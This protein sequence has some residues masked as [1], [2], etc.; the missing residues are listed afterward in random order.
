MTYCSG[1]RITASGIEITFMVIFKAQIFYFIFISGLNH[2][3]WGNRQ[4]EKGRQMI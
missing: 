4:T 1:F 2:C 3:Q